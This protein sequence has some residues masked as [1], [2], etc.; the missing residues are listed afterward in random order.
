MRRDMATEMT[1]KLAL[2]RSQVRIAWRYSSSIIWERACRP[3]HNVYNIIQDF[4][5]FSLP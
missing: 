3:F 5:S 4:C 1:D 2:F